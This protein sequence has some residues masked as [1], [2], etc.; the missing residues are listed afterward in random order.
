[1]IKVNE[2]RPTDADLNEYRERG[3][4]ITPK[5]LPDDQ[6]EQLRKE[7]DRI[8][9]YDYDRDIYPFDRVYTYDLNSPELRKV[10]NG[11]WLNDNIRSLVLSQKLGALVAPLMETDEVRIWHDQVVVK[12]GVGPERKDFAAANVGWH[13][14]YAHWQVASSQKMC[15]LWLAL[16]DTDLTNGGMRTIVGS[17]KW[18]LVPNSDSFH[19]KDLDGLKDK[20]AGTHEWIDEPC[21][22]KAGCASIHHCLCFHGSGPNLTHDPR[23]SVIIHY[24]PGGTSY[25]GRIDPFATIQAG[26]KG[27][28]HANV[29]LLGP[30][31]KPGDLF[32]GDCFPKVWPTS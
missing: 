28:R 3:Y 16:Q 1:M 11:W 30:N 25:R 8:F 6:I 5:L 22:L 29:P 13:Q 27:N 24:M 19:D 12:P 21:I 15:T 18:G 20:Y 10:N 31:A 17:H 9:K 26:R 7:V 32:V 23:L 14:D 4:W 2:V